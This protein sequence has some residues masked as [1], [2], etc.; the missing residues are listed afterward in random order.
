MAEAIT[1]P[2]GVARSA[3]AAAAPFEPLI[4]RLTFAAHPARG[5]VI[6]VT[7]AIDGEGKTTAARALALAFAG[8]G[9]WERPV[10]LVDG[11]MPDGVRGRK[12]REL[13][14]QW[15]QIVQAPNL[16]VSTPSSLATE[17]MP[18]RSV[19]LSGTFDAMRARHPF[20]VLDLPSLMAD[21]VATE[22]ARAVDRLYLVV[23]C[24]AAPASLLRQAIDRV[25]Q[26]RVDGVILNDAR[27]GAPGWL[28]RLVS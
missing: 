23:R 2:L 27:A 24:G 3:D 5:M 9:A 10:L 14:R 21:P 20:I 28:A 19:V 13:H 8:E 11:G 17:G 16:K 22:L 26:E 7:S 1:Y 6:G 12:G 4:R 15:Q 18:L 25:G